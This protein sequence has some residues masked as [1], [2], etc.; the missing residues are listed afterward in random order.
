MLWIWPLHF[1]NRSSIYG[2]GVSV[3]VY[4][5]KNL[6]FHI[7]VARHW[8][9]HVFIPFWLFNLSIR[10]HNKYLI[11]QSDITIYRLKSIQ[12]YRASHFLLALS[13]P[14]KMAPP[15]FLHLWSQYIF[16]YVCIMPKS[17]RINNVAESSRD[18][19]FT[20]N[21]CVVIWFETIGSLIHLLY[22][23]TLNCRLLAR[24]TW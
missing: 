7:K 11:Y 8:E 24:L 3:I 6:E 14:Q 4:C 19:S 22:F 12:P 21:S 23:S 16:V 1:P 17:L 13:Q 20:K 15:L 9:F 5:K 10:Y 2:L 18:I